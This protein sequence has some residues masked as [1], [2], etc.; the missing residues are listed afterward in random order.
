MCGIT[1]ICR[2]YKYNR[3]YIYRVE[4]LRLEDFWRDHTP[5]NDGATSRWIRRKES[6]CDSSEEATL[7]K[8]TK[9]TIETAFRESIDDHPSIKDLIVTA[10]GGICDQNSTKGAKITINRNEC[11]EHVHPHEYNVYDF[12]TFTMLH[13]G[14]K[15]AL[16]AGRL[17]PITKFANQIPEDEHFDLI[18]PS[19]H[20]MDRWKKMTTTLAQYYKFTKMGKHLEY[21][22]F[23]NLHTAV[24]T[25]QIAEFINATA[26]AIDGGL[27]EACGSPGEVE[28]IPKLG[29]SYYGCPDY[30]RGRLAA[31]TGIEPGWD[32]DR[33]ETKSMLWQNMA[34]KADDQLRHRVAWALSQI[35]VVAQG[36]LAMSLLPQAECY[37]AYY[38]IFVRHAFGS[39]RDIMREVA[40]SPL[41]GLYLTFKGNK[42][43]E[44]GKLP[45]ENF[46][47]EIMQ[48]F[49]IGLFELEIDGTIK[50]EAAGGGDTYTNADI[51]TF[52]RAWTGFDLRSQRGRSKSL[53]ATENLLENTDGVGAPHHC[54][55]HHCSLGA[56]PCYLPF[57]LTRAILM[58]S[59]FQ[60]QLRRR[61]LRK[62]QLL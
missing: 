59:L 60:R 47:R 54:S 27:F 12:T 23:A 50:D 1:I 26:V 32:V 20:G 3:R 52:A 4:G 7:D 14:T 34:F 5:C 18:F 29:N 46:A 42:E 15:V 33:E 62:V 35:F 9:T 11:W 41:M 25:T 28:T 16:A 21:V 43:A 53:V 61:Q 56:A 49:S 38:D 30:G 31:C 58:P 51:A 13:P 19:F 57:M 39:Y 6:R 48:L 45:D 55:L 40:A 2:R 36:S 24:Q 17:D 10:K 37:A 44:G 8:D 22:T